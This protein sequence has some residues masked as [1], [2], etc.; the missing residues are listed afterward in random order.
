MLRRRPKFSIYR[1]RERNTRFQ[2]VRRA[3]RLRRLL[4]RESRWLGT[5]MT[6]K[7]DRRGLSIGTRP[8]KSSTLTRR[9]CIAGF[10]QRDNRKL[11]AS[12]RIKCFLCRH[13][14]NPRWTQVRKSV[15]CCG[16]YARAPG[17]A[18]VSSGMA[19]L[20][21]EIV[22]RREAN[23]DEV[24]DGRK[25]ETKLFR[26]GES[27][28]KHAICERRMREVEIRMCPPFPATISNSNPIKASKYCIPPLR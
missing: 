25:L 3:A 22:C 11:L 4:R 9:K 5:S 19:S 7:G 23:A 17:S 26:L 1:I 6:R 8:L 13:E 27:L 15:A 20:P 10:Q 18:R 2:F 24:R 28:L 16:Y 12:H 14:S 21:L